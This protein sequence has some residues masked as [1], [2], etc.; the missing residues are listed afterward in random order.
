MRYFAPPTVGGTVSDA[1]IQKRLFDLMVDQ[2]ELDPADLT[3]DADLRDDLDLDSLDAMDL[4]A[5]VEKR[6]GLTVDE[7]RVLRVRT[8]GELTEYLLSL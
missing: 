3:P 6:M 7:E 1:D 5:L 2:F 4:M 8:V